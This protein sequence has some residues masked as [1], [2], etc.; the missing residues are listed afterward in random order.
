MYAW[1]IRGLSSHGTT[2]AYDRA[3]LGRSSPNIVP[4]DGEGRAAELHELILALKLEDPLILIGHSI[5]GLYL[6]V[7]AHHYRDYT[8]ALVFLDATHTLVHKLFEHRQPFQ[9]RTRM[10][11]AHCGHWLGVTRLPFPLERASQMPWATL[12][13]EA[14]C[15]VEYL[16]GQPRAAVTACAER[17]L[18]PA[19]SQQAKACGTLN[20]LPI[21]VI[22]AGIRTPRELRYEADAEGFME[23]WLLLQKD[24]TTLSSHSVFLAIEGAGHCDLVTDH[25][26]ATQGVKA[27]LQF[28]ESHLIEAAPHV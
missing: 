10:V 2:I 14:R 13:E 21:L 11:L 22:S 24:L 19:A 15:E 27:I 25:R 17:A 6:R 8:R 1:L 18:L 16:S 7:F 9:D 26:F 20:N 4:P 12:P 5:A 3:G 23:K 28:T